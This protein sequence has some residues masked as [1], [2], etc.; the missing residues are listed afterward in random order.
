VNQLAPN[1]YLAVYWANYS[2]SCI[3]IA[4]LGYGILWR[5]QKTI[6]LPP[7]PNPKVI[8]WW[9]N[10]KPLNRCGIFY[11]KRITLFNQFKV[12]V[13][14]PVPVAQTPVSPPRRLTIVANSLQVVLLS[15]P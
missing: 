2:A 12:I 3:A 10:A 1:K 5:L 14:V 6:N 13:M 8:A 9:G 15:V 4:K 11:E 7:S